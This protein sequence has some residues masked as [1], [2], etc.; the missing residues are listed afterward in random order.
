[1]SENIRVNVDLSL[2]KGN[3]D[4]LQA[5]LQKKEN[6]RRVNQFIA[7]VILADEDGIEAN[8]VGGYAHRCWSEDDAPCSFCRNNL[9]DEW[10]CGHYVGE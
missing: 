10:P 8:M 7:N 1:M 2:K 3:V 6:V 4:K 5:V 9:V